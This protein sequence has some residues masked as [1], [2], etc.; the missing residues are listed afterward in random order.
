[1]L[2]N[3]CKKLDRQVRA[4]NYPAKQI[5]QTQRTCCNS[6]ANAKAQSQW[7]HLYQQQCHEKRNRNNVAAST[8]TQKKWHNGRATT[9]VIDHEEQMFPC[10]TTHLLKHKCSPIP[11]KLSVLYISGKV[12]TA[13]QKRFTN[14]N[15]NYGH[16]STMLKCFKSY[17]SNKTTSNRKDNGG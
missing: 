16:W 4:Q 14:P 11:L 5:A 3:S 1:M 17:N 6:R 13:C 15:Q 10:F 7:Q 9:I 12:R 2:N 8:G